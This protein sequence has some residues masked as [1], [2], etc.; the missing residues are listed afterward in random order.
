MAWFLYSSSRRVWSALQASTKCL[1]Y[2]PIMTFS[3]PAPKQQSPM[4]S[5]SI[6]F[7]LLSKFFH[8]FQRGGGWGLWWFSGIAHSVVEWMLKDLPLFKWRKGGGKRGTFSF[9]S[10]INSSRHKFGH[11]FNQR[12][13]RKLSLLRKT[14]KTSTYRKYCE[15]T[16]QWW[17]SFTWSLKV[18]KGTSMATCYLRSIVL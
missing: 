1:L 12:P 15:V 5:A 17:R 11:I 14:A 10:V 4:R 13:K 9:I 2:E 3:T 16:A 7:C 18:F 6:V 8:I